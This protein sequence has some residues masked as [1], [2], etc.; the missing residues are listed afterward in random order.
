M[1]PTS[2]M[3]APPARCGKSNL[4]RLA[5]LG[6]LPRS[7]KASP[8][9]PTPDD[10]PGSDPVVPALPAVRQSGGPWSGVR[11]RAGI[12]APGP[13]RQAAEVEVPPALVV[14]ALLVV[15][16]IMVAQHDAGSAVFR[17]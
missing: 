2:V 8:G 4:S 13:G 6:T 14:L 12:L 7:R 16:Q 15:G 9:E 5:P 3:G 17:L 10:S 1:F 11:I